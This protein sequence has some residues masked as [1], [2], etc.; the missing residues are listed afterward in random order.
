MVGCVVVPIGLGDMADALLHSAMPRV[1]TP[2][3]TSCCSGSAVPHVLLLWRVCSTGDGRIRRAD[4]TALSP[5]G[6]RRAV[7]GQRARRDWQRGMLRPHGSEGAGHVES[8]P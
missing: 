7:D 2:A 6:E 8:R 1:A 3:S 4:K 5:E